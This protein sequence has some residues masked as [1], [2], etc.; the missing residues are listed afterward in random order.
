[1]AAHYVE[2]LCTIGVE[3]GLFGPRE[4]DRVWERHVLP[5]A[6]LGELVPPGVRVADVGSGAGLPGIPLAIARPD[7]AVTLVEPMLRRVHFL[8]EVVTELGLAAVTVVRARGE[9]AAVEVDVVV[10]RAVAPLTRL[11]P[12]TAPLLVD[13]GTVLAVKGR[14]AQD[15]ID[16]AVDVLQKWQAHAAVTSVGD[17]TD[18]TTVVVVDVAADRV[19]SQAQRD[20]GRRTKSRGAK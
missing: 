3:R 5:A 19:R 4:P 13:G 20:S 2:L 10:A 16:A 8:E 17:G 14:A 1:M 18:V 7:L 9:S 6:A 12:T 15:E 11:L